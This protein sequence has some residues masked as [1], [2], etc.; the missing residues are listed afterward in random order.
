VRDFI[1]RCR[2]ESNRAGIDHTLIT[3]NQ[4]P[5]RA[6]RDYLQRRGGKHIAGHAHRPMT[7]LAR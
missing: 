2:A 1:A 6:L 5:E 3:T 7:H 4:A